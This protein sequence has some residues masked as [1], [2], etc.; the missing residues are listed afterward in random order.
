[1]Q[2]KLLK[3]MFKAF[4][5]ESAFKTLYFSLVQSQIENIFLIRYTDNIN[6]HWNLFAIQNNFSTYYT[7]PFNV[8]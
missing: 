8:M 7:Y 6:Q 3:R 1:M 2:L 4:Y 5:D